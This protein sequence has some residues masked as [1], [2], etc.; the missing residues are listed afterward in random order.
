MADEPGDA[1]Q[2]LVQPLSGFDTCGLG[3]MCWGVDPKTSLGWCVQQCEGSPQAPVCSDPNMVCSTANEGVL[4]LCLRVCDPDGDDCPAGQACFSVGDDFVCGPEPG[5]G[6]PP[7]APGT[8]CEEIAAC[9]PGAVCINGAI[10]GPDCE[11]TAC[12][13][14]QCDLSAPECS[15]PDQQCLPLFGDGMA[16]PG[17][18]DAGICGIS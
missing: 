11:S 13:T 6:G 16:P 1:C 17:S 14:E 18:E 4:N 5:R 8:S 3:A 2:V 7:G 10:Y 9:D 15:H 12:C